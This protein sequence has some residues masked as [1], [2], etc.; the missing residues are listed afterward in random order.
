[1]KPEVEPRPNAAEIPPGA[2]R[3]LG[4]K[5]GM[6][7]EIHSYHLERSDPKIFTTDPQLADLGRCVT[8]SQRS[9]DLS[10]G[11][12]GLT[13]RSS[14]MSGLGEAVERYCAYCP[15]PDRFVEATYDELEAEGHRL[16]PV[17]Y[18]DLYDESQY[19]T[20]RDLT[21]WR[22]PFDRETEIDWCAGRNL[23]TGA[24]TYVPAQLVYLAR[25]PTDSVYILG[26]SNGLAGG[27]SI[28]SAL[29]GSL[30]ECFERDAVMKTW[31]GAETPGRIATTPFEGLHRLRTSMESDFVSYLPLK[32]DTEFGVETVG[33]AVV[34]RRRDGPRFVLAAA[35]SLSTTEAVESALV[36]AAQGAIYVTHLNQ[37]YRN[38]EVDIRRVTNF[39]DNVAYYLAP[40]NFGEV[41]FLLRGDR[42]EVRPTDP[43]P[44]SAEEELRQCLSAAAD[45]G[46]TP[47]GFDLTTRDARDAGFRVTR[48]FVPELVSLHLPALPPKNHPRF[49]QFAVTDKPHPFP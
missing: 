31:Y 28:E 10:A 35:A 34:D 6:V 14:I 3:L 5:G 11:G 42:V 33:C 48:V 46:L 16:P 39:E 41:R 40:E 7:G 17:E 19:G 2:W 15:F 20:L 49:R 47:V 29:V 36:E 18:L 44:D 4:S 45:A 21:R 12:K 23:L 22:E 43:A 37:R 38:R 30:Y 8:T 1:M 24:R 26:T 32:L 9:V 25:E 27:E 13:L